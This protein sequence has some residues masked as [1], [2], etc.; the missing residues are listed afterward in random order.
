ML[1]H[2]FFNR[3]LVDSINGTELVMPVIC[4]RD[5]LIHGAINGMYR[6]LDQS[7]PGGDRVSLETLIQKMPMDSSK[8]QNAEQ[9]L[10]G[11]RQSQDWQETK[12]IRHGR[13]AHSLDNK[14][15]KFI[16]WQKLSN[17][18]RSLIELM[19]LLRPGF[20]SEARQNTGEWNRLS[21]QFWKK[22]I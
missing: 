7:K 11:I 10:L 14:G 2:F 18:R 9:K 3:E 22:L 20:A 21:E 12:T 16:C 19:D 5:D 6:L 8:K 4:I 15:E 17:I 13:I 1:G